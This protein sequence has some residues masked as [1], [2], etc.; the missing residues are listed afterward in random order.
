[1]AETLK[2]TC[3]DSPRGWNA[4]DGKSCAF[5]KREQLCTP[6]GRFG[7]RWGSTYGKFEDWA[8]NG[9]SADQACCACGGGKKTLGNGTGARKP[10]EN[11]TDASTS[12]PCENS[13]SD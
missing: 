9:V 13:K 4:S 8:N 2:E 1:M 3:V 5:Y 12:T 6:T 10:E 7:E 11:S